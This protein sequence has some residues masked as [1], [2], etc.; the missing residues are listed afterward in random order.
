MNIIQLEKVT[1]QYKTRARRS[2]Q[3]GD[4]PWY[5]RFIPTTEVITAVDSISLEIKRKEIVGLVGLNGSGKSTTIKLITGILSP[6][7]GTVK[8]FGLDPIRKRKEVTRRF[9]VMFGQ[10]SLLWYHL[11]AYKSLLLYKEIYQLDKKTF[12]QQLEWL[13]DALGLHDL[14]HRPVRSLSLGQRMRVEIAAAMIHLPELLILDEPF[15]GLDFMVKNQIR[16]F[17]LQ[18]NQD[19]ENPLTILIADHDLIGLED[20]CQRL[21]L[22]H[23]GRI[24]DDVPLKTFKNRAESLR[25]IECRGPLEEVKKIEKLLHDQVEWMETIGN[26]LRMT[27]DTKK[28]PMDEFFSLIDEEKVEDVH[29]SNVPLQDILR[30]LYMQEDV[31]D[32]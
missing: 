6:T 9:G 24:L 21:V 30:L 2:S 1:K 17:L 22:L 12:R 18:L 27:I 3:N 5:R 28:L 20:I 14:L 16:K 19:A 11:P 23:R 29:V 26:I 4:E 25:R 31:N 7:R 8:V 10:R 32:G 15:I 13:T